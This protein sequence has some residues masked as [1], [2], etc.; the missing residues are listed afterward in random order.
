ME[1]SA[2]K[3]AEIPA[4]LPTV[5]LVCARSPGS[6]TVRI[7]STIAFAM[8]SVTS[9]L[10]PG[11][12]E[13]MTLIVPSCM[14][15]MKVVGIRLIRRSDAANTPVVASSVS[16]R[17]EKH[18]ASH[19]A[20]LS[21]SLCMRFCTASSG[22]PFLWVFTIRGDMLASSG[23]NVML[24]KRLIMSA[25]EMVIDRSL[26]TCP[27]IPFT[28]SM[29]MKTATV[30]RVDAAMAMPTWL[31]PRSAPSF[32]PA[33]SLRSRW[34]F[35]ST[36]TE[37][38]TIMPIAIERPAR[39][40]MLRLTSN[41]YMNANVVTKDSGIVMLTIPAFTGEPR[42]S[43]RTIAVRTI[44]CMPDSSREFMEDFT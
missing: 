6:I 12:A 39:E 27:V 35:S 19:P 40:T 21:S 42:N 30:V 1:A 31:P 33:P 41:T 8:L 14:S 43:S 9:R 36:T 17:C 4:P 3:T 37:L 15:G 16:L 44:A 28:K 2:P 24:L 32:T 29:G 5:M 26:K 7:E 20:Y 22:D 25:Q 23:T 38:S 13:A 11:G 34:M 10:V 18:Q